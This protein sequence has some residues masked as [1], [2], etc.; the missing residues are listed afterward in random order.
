MFFKGS[1]G[2]L[3]MF[4]YVQ[5]YTFITKIDLHYPAV[6]EHFYFLTYIPVRHSVIAVI[7]GK[8]YMIVALDGKGVK[9]LRSK[10]TSNSRKTHLPQRV[11]QHARIMV[12][13][14][15]E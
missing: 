12:Q 8:L 15:Q 3:M 4:V 1:V 2:F 5:G 10:M 11:G 9:N 6:I 14:K 13:H 7:P